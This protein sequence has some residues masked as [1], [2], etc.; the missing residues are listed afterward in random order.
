MAY[1]E[2]HARDQ[3]RLLPAS[4][5][6]LPDVRAIGDDLAVRASSYSLRECSRSVRP[7]GQLFFNILASFGEFEADLIRMRTFEGIAVA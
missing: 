5:D 6:R 1:I 4:P 2:G 3:A 7:D